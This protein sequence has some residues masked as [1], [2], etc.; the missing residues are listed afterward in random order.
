MTSD[1]SK[2]RRRLIG[3]R[4]GALEKVGGSG[5]TSNTTIDDA[6]AVDKSMSI[7]I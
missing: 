3:G 7:C 4:L 6:P 1:R 5:I 2:P